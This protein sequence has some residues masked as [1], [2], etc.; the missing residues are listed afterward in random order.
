MRKNIW[1]LI[2]IALLM[3]LLL[4]TD[5]HA[6][7]AALEKVRGLPII[8]LLFLQIITIILVAVQ[9]KLIAASMRQPLAFKT[10]LSMNMIGTFFE[11]VTPAVKSGGEVSK[12]VFL[13]KHGFTAA[14]SGALIGGQKAISMLGFSLLL[15]LTIIGLITLFPLAQL[16]DVIGLYVLFAGTLIVLALT[17]YLIL[18]G[19]K[20]WHPFVRYT[21]R[22]N[23]ARQSVKQAFAYLKNDRKRLVL[24]LLLAASIWTLYALKTHIIMTAVGLEISFFISAAAIFSGYMVGLLPLTPG[25]LGTFESAFIGIGLL[26]GISAT[27]GL[28]VV[29]VV[30]LATF[31]FSLLISALYLLVIRKHTYQK[32][33]D[34]A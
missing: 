3:F 12:Y 6:L 25:G 4:N 14:K 34:H 21:E 2:G 10:I 33:F 5:Y 11:S 19:K 13:K 22:I 8:I 29:M 31:W 7:L 23:E 24:H 20:V 17:V 16:K 28:S 32:A 15:T 30:R 9:W 27:L 18:R 1:M 26:F